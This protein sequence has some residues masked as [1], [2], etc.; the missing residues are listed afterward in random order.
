MH[1]ATE[2]DFFTRDRIL[3]VFVGANGRN[4]AFYA[5]LRH[6][7]T[8]LYELIEAEILI[9]ALSAMVNNADNLIRAQYNDDFTWIRNV[10]DAMPTICGDCK[11]ILIGSGTDTRIKDRQL[12]DMIYDYFFNDY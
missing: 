4:G 8:N 1:F 9:P 12:S 6:E 3:L 11:Y 5:F 10:D 7:I 2:H